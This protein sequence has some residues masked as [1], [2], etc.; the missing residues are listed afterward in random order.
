[1]GN[2]DYMSNDKITSEQA[3]RLFAEDILKDQQNL[4]PEV[5]EI[6][7]T[8]L[9]DSLSSFINKE[10]VIRLNEK[11]VKEFNDL[12][13]TNPSDEATV[14]FFQ[15]NGVNIDEAVQSAMAK[16]RIAYIG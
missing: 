14:A 3:M 9:V 8:D 10:L 7:V 6:M 12:L 4:D 16:F 15:N 5:K 1:M 13:D 2:C 11:Q